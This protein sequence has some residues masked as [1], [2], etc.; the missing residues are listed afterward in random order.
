MADGS[1]LTGTN[2]PILHI[3][4]TTLTQHGHRYR[5][6][7]TDATPATVDS[8]DAT[9]SIDYAEL[10]GM[11]SNLY[12]QLGGGSLGY[13]T[14]PKQV[15]SGISAVAV[16]NNHTLFLRS[17]GTLWSAGWNYYGQL[18]D[19][20]TVNRSIPVKIASGV[21]SIAAA[22]D[23]SYF[24]KGDHSL[25][26]CGFNSSYQ[27]GTGDMI[28]AAT[29]VQIASYVRQV[30]A[31]PTYVLLVK[32]DDSLWAVGTGSFGQLGMGSVIA[33]TPLQI[34]E[35]V[36]AVA[37]GANH[38]L[39]IKHDGTLWGMGASSLGQLLSV[40][41]SAFYFPV[42][43]G[44]GYTAVAAGRDH[45]IL[46]KGDGSV[47][48]VG[49]N[50]YGQ[51]GIGST[52]NQSAPIQ[53]ASNA[54]KIGA[55]FYSSWI[56][57]DDGTLLVFGRN[58]H[59]M[60]GDGSMANRLSPFALASDVTTAAGNTYHFLF[61]QTDGTAWAVGLNDG[62]QFGDGSQAY[63]TEPVLVADEVVSFTA[64]G[65]SSLYV[66][67]DGLLWGLGSNQRGQLGDENLQDRASAV[68]VHDNVAEVSSG[69]A[70]TVFR[71]RDGS[72]WGMGSNQRGQLAGA[73]ASDQLHPVQIASDVRQAFAGSSSNNTYFFTADGSF[74]GLGDNSTGQLGIGSSVTMMTVPV[75]IGSEVAQAS[76][77]ANH[78]LLL[79]ADA[80]LWSLGGN[81][82]GQTGTGGTATVYVPVQIA[83]DV[84]A[85]TAG[86]SYSFYRKTDGA[87]YALGS[88]GEGQLGLGTT[89]TSQLTPAVVAGEFTASFAG[90]WHSLHLKAD[91][92]LWTTGSNSYGQLGDGT[93]IQR[94]WPVHVADGV[95][96]AQGGFIHSLFLR[97]GAPVAP[98]IVVQ[99]QDLSVGSNM[100]AVM[101]VQ[102]TGFPTPQYQWRKGGVDIPGATQADFRIL[103]ARVEDTGDYDVVVSSTLGI[104]ES[105]TATLTVSPPVAPAI[106]G[107]PVG[108]FQIVGGTHSL[109]VTATGTPPLAY[110]WY[111]DGGIIP[112]ATAE[113]LIL[114][115]L[116]P[117]DAGSYTVVVSNEVGPV[118]SSEAEVHVELPTVIGNSSS[119]RI[120]GTPGQPL[121]LNVEATSAYAPLTY[122]WK[123][124]N[125]P[126]A[127]ATGASLTT[128]AFTND[129]AGAY[130][131]EI[132]DIHGF[133]TR[134]TTFVLPHYG[135]TQVIAWGDSSRYAEPVAS[136]DWPD[137]VAANARPGGAYLLRRD[138]S[139]LLRNATTGVVS[140]VTELSDIVAM[141]AGDLTD[142]F[143]RADGTVA[144]L[145]GPS[146]SD[147]APPAGLSGVIAIG[148]GFN[149]TLALLSDGTVRAWGQNSDG[150]TE[151]PVGLG[152]VTAIAVGG[153]HNLALKVDGTVVAWGGNYNDQCNV[154][155]GLSGVDRIVAYNNQ[156]YAMKTDGT[157]VAWGDPFGGTVAAAA[158]LSN[159]RDLCVGPQ[160]GFALLQDG[161]VQA[162]AVEPMDGLSP[163]PA[164][165]APVVAISS[166]YPPMLAIRDS[167]ADAAPVITVQPVA[168][169]RLTHTEH[170]FTVT[171]SGSGP[172]FY[173]WRRNGVELPAGVEASLSLR[174]LSVADAGNYDVV[175][176]S[177]AG[178]VI[179]Q[180]ATLTVRPV[181]EI[182]Q[183][184]P[185]RNMVAPGETLSLSVTATGTGVL[186]Y[187]WYRDGQPL[188]GATSASFSRAPATLADSGCYW[189]VVTDEIS[190][191][192]SA[193]SFVRVR[194]TFTQVRGWGRNNE[195]ETTIPA[196]LQD[197]IAVGAG[198]SFAAAIRRDGTVVDWG[199]DL[200]RPRPI[201]ND[202]VDLAVGFRCYIAL[203]SDGTVVGYDT[204][205]A[206]ISIPSGLGDVMAIAAG[207]T[208]FAA[209]K[210]DGSVVTW[211]SP[212]S[213]PA[214]TG[215]IKAVTWQGNTLVALKTDGTV[216]F[217][218]SAGSGLHIS[219]LSQVVQ[220]S[221]GY[222]L[223]SNGTMV[224][225]DFGN[226]AYTPIDGI[227]DA[228]AI[229]GSPNHLLVIHANGSVTAFGDNSY[230]QGNVPADLGSPVLAV[231]AGSAFSLAL[232]DISTATAPQIVDQP[233]ALTVTEMQA[234]T[235]TVIATGGTPMTYQWRR[236]NE[237]VPGATAATLVIA[238]SSTADAGTYDVVIGN[239]LGEV[240]SE[241]VSLTIVPIPAV[242]LTVSPW[243]VLVPGSALTM[244]VTATGTG[245]LSYQWRRNG[246]VIS[247][248][249]APEL[250]I[251][252]AGYADEGYYFVNVTDQ[253]GTRRSQVTFVRVAPLASEVIGWGDNTK[254]RISGA[255]ETMTDLVSLSVAGDYVLALRRDGRLVAWGDTTYL[256]ADPPT[257][258]GFVDMVAMEKSCF[259]LRSDGTVVGWGV[260]D[261]GVLE[262]PSG[263]KD[264]VALS[265]GSDTVMA[266]RK[267]GSVVVWGGQAIYQQPPADLPPAAAVN[268]R[269]AFLYAVLVDGRVAVWDNY[270][271]PFTG[272]PY[273]SLYTD[274]VAVEGAAYTSVALRP[275]GTVLTWGFT[276]FFGTAAVPPG[277]SGV[278][279]LASGGRHMLA[280]KTDGSV[281][282]WGTAVQSAEAN[283]VPPGVSGVFAIAAGKKGSLALRDAT[284]PTQPFFLV[285]PQAQTIAYQQALQLE[286]EAVATPAPTYQWRR[287]G[288]A[289]AGATQGTFVVAAATFANGG[290]YDVVATNSTGFTV[291]QV[292]SILMV[293]A[294]Q[295]IDV[296]PI[297]YQG[298]STNPITLTATATSGLPVEFVL[299][300]GPAILVGNQLTLTGAGQ[301][302]VQARQA[303]NE[304]FEAAYNI[305]RNIMI[306]AN[307]ASW[308]WDRFDAAERADPAVS[309]PQADPDQ[310]GLGNLME[311]ALGS[312][313]KMSSLDA[314]PTVS[315]NSTHWL[316]TYT[317]SADR[318]DLQ[319][320]VEYSTDLT[321]WVEVFAGDLTQ[322]EGTTTTRTM[323]ARQPISTA[324][325]YFRLKVSTQ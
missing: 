127:G 278:R 46:L 230:G 167:S 213:I 299:L 310:D 38:S 108:T 196:N 162:V 187:Q 226:E 36:M 163:M 156:S 136:I 105:S 34:A 210:A 30:A 124:D 275:D 137:I 313:P 85:I 281:V 229:S 146:S 23:Q 11:G 284:A 24:L 6:R 179:S 177:H 259:A 198:T 28:N 254:G 104:V 160:Y 53:M 120:I 285:H 200:G 10:W 173:Q 175:I 67:S 252:A 59:G 20:K 43:L 3:Q 227:T 1:G 81:F 234:A 165:L 18:G 126:I 139:V 68:L 212:F 286:A 45:T 318:P 231:A 60:M 211:G 264:I 117:A 73:P 66:R 144:V 31:G 267:D 125:R 115:N 142:V 174:N 255:P 302:T 14:T 216:R 262:I 182:T 143:L 188:A 150:R 205:Y 295:S 138:G 76:A 148:K 96:A 13:R 287:N 312:D 40:S 51:I 237:P 62:G 290:N 251:P 50:T 199:F 71:K 249:T 260:N 95:N 158:T 181:P 74:W 133:V 75:Q 119:T 122:Q 113:S 141:S 269:G 304:Y 19:G 283:V 270:F 112:G 308:F 248:A 145:R 297:P 225:L 319:Y 9:L 247:G 228:V 90:G 135:Q 106:T 218:L 239:Y 300:S 201:L 98:S 110:Q 80:T 273:P 296:T 280:L 242:S 172:L 266:L 222:A 220:I 322:I 116:Q 214:E 149:H 103:A 170:V 97:R 2:A 316:F 256:Q 183:Q 166:R 305:D 4:S 44:S 202:A 258:S 306:E 65:N 77:G 317:R 99:P 250:T 151:V 171:A 289:I 245:T 190:S 309:G 236:N 206:G 303:G 152:D 193:L 265:A 293:K 161:S 241:P 184:A 298:F 93:R 291:S 272:Q 168:A 147:P 154:P 178:S 49:G 8:A 72:L 88:G 57:K 153:S 33:Q 207:S 134:R 63:M 180:P 123:K 185:A 132:T 282:G 271:H 58:S 52:I 100:T 321:L 233:D 240:T 27:L 164:N 107:Q 176:S 79:K 29:P 48:T 47:W 243:Q 17:D 101:T 69:I 311:Y 194:P 157:V 109:S 268:A 78:L 140:P 189:V 217:W 92:S 169:E 56:L 197:A 320:T 323:Q 64:A 128:G 224:A 42:Q 118:T 221:N 314:L 26:A 87:L 121:V 274:I 276:D 41:A 86:P 91:G 238:E 324:N 261:Y 232:I 111:R 209:L 325:I 39:F 129:A 82:Y 223:R 155:A 279:A 61:T 292:A 25:W 21:T 7:V 131:V 12:G 186:T 203:R 192:R 246:R 288:S 89:A 5:V 84:T 257:E 253:N 54:V 263:L 219:G 307:F 22:G 215:P 94:D 130:T 15:A 37:A 315:S 70:H 294:T 208:T 55:G 235:L 35:N 244:G 301:I 83:T 32:D 102:T 204:G 16:G 114:T 195:A 191:S 159:V 277:L